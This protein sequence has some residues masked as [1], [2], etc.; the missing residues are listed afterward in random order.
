MYL[1][2]TELGV[3]KS[4]FSKE[5][6]LAGEGRGEEGAGGEMDSMNSSE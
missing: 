4:H 5:K 6:E 2:N 3:F 1:T